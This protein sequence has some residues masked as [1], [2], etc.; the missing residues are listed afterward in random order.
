[1]PAMTEKTK[2]R[3]LKVMSVDPE[4]LFVEK[5]TAN[6]ERNG[7]P[8]KKVSLPLQKVEAAA[9]AD[10]LDLEMIL[11]RLSMG[12]IYSCQFEGKIYFAAEAISAA[13]FSSAP[14]EPAPGA[15]FDPSSLFGGS[16]PDLSAFAGKDP[17][18]MQQQA[19]QMMNDMDPQQRQQLMEMWMNMLQ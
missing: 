2:K 13:D 12:G 14:V 8:E 3:K 7:F 9:A 5:I 1:M 17:Q 15:G 19:M 6:L 4:D 10:E 11:S 16:M 18:E